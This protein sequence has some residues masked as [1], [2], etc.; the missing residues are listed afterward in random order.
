MQKTVWTVK[1]CI[2]NVVQLSPVLVVVGC[3]GLYFAV[4]GCTG[5]NWA[6]LDC[7]GQYWTVLGSAGLY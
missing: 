6:L 2:S 1:S 3:S 4:L 5:L 7:T